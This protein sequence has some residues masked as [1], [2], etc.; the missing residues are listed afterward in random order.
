MK[1]H[2]E[3]DSA[4]LPVSIVDGVRVLEQEFEVPDGALP[5]RMQVGDAPVSI[6]GWVTPGSGAVPALLRDVAS[7]VERI[8]A[9]R[10]GQ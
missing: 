8:E 10:A 4:G 9:E 2:I 5:V 7:E 3:E 6:I 1:L